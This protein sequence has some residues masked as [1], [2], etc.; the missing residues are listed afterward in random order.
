MTKR[1]LRIHRAKSKL[2]ESTRRLE[3]AT[4]LGRE[5]LIEYYAVR[6]NA[7]QRKIRRYEGVM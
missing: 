7:A 5:D 3:N 2:M 4:L 1:E 6:I